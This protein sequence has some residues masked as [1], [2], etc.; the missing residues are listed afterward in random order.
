M[1]LVAVATVL[2]DSAV[3]VLPDTAL[4]GKLTAARL[5]ILVGLVAVALSGGRWRDLRS[6]LDLPIAL[7]VVAGTATTVIGDHEAAP[8]RSLLTVVGGYYLTVGVLRRD[9]QAF[10]ALSLLMLVAVG[11]AGSVALAQSAQSTATGFCRTLTF[12]EVAC[13]TPGVVH[14]SIGTFTNPNLLAA[15]LLLFGPFAAAAAWRARPGQERVVLF[16]LVFVGYAGLATT[17]SRMGCLAALVTAGLAAALVWSR[18]RIRVRT[19]LLG[20]GLLA[21]AGAAAVIALDA[22]GLR[23][24]AWRLGLAAWRDRPLTGVGLGRAGDVIGTGG[25]G[26]DFR[27]AHNLWLNALVEAGPVALIA[28]VLITVLGMTVAVRAAAARQTGGLAG[29]TALTG[30]FLM[31]LTDHPA[32]A[33]RIHVA[34]WLALALVMAPRAGIVLPPD[35]PTSEPEVVPSEPSVPALLRS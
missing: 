9:P 31:S 3:P 14:R 12:A 27:H 15:F 11:L 10:G 24:T 32:A 20:A 26:T 28:V 18:G 25:T 29:L 21:L 6:P 30:F 34:W 19:L 4:I 2:L 35:P 22:L 17:F 8:L 23:L 16:G 1:A 33:E 13:G 5:A 7:L